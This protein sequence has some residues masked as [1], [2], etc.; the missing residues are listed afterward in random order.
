MRLNLAIRSVFCVWCFA[1]VSD[2]K[3]KAL[4]SKK[5]SLCTFKAVYRTETPGIQ[6][7]ETPSHGYQKLQ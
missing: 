2:D 5:M 7:H 4:S 1:A 6:E 3:Q